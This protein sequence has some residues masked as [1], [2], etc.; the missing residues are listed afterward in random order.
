MSACYDILDVVSGELCMTIDIDMRA[1]IDS[2]TYQYGNTTFR[3]ATPDS[4]IADIFNLLNQ[5]GSASLFL[6]CVVVHR[7][8]D[9]ALRVRQVSK[10]SVATGSSP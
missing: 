7:Q 10:P 8:R 1:T 2:R 4:V 6:D 9:G 3:G 5:I